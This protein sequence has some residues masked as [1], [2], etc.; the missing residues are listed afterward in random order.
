[1]EELNI[2]GRLKIVYDITTLE[3]A[4]VAKRPRLP[5]PHPKVFVRVMLPV[6]LHVGFKH[7]RKVRVVFVGLEH[8]KSIRPIMLDKHLINRVVYRVGVKVYVKL[9]PL[10]P[11]SR[12]KLV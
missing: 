7:V 6:P 11:N 3:H 10:C 1:M 4:S 12:Y 5:L 8:N 2:I 9:R